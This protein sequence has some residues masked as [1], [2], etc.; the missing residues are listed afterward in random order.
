MV[1]F[2]DY[3]EPVPNFQPVSAAERAR[4]DAA[5]A[6]FLALGGQIEQVEPQRMKGDYGFA[7]FVLD[8]KR[9][10]LYAH[11]FEAPTGAVEAVEEEATSTRTG[12]EA[13]VRLAAK[14]MAEASLGYPP[15]RIARR[16]GL[17]EKRVRQ[18]CRDYRISFKS[19]Q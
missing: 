2:N 7:D 12:D 11:L 1:N 14:V 8:P 18:L 10:P 9:T 17:P 16:L 19:Q 3:S 15:A 13:E 6:E 5:A 4:L